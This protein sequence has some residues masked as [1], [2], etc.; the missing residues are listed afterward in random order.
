MEL[1]RQRFEWVTRRNAAPSRAIHRHIA[2]RLY[3]LH[4][5]YL[6]IGFDD[7]LDRDF[8]LLQLRRAGFLRDQFV[9]VF[10]N[11]LKHLC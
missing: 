7:E 6:A 2:G 5:G 11:G 4:S 10:A 1:F 3:N 8:P 9:P